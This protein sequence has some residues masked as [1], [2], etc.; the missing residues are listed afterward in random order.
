MFAKPANE[1]GLRLPDSTFEF[2]A[3]QIGED[4]TLLAENERL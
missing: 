3:F 1:Q 4:E 2:V